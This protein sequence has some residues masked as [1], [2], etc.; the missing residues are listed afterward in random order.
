MI[1]SSGARRAAAVLDMISGLLVSNFRVYTRA[2]TATRTPGVPAIDEGSLI[3]T[4]P[5]SGEEVGRFPV[6]SP[7]DVTDAV[8]RARDAA[9]WWA[10]LGFAG[11]RKRL[12]AFRSVVTNRLEELAELMHREG[13]KPTAD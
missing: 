3:S 10:G 2:M 6:A 4:S 13:G 5:S 9:G 12:L 8:A 7:D 11:R 1:S